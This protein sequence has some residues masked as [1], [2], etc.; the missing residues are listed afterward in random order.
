MRTIF[1]RHCRQ[2]TAFLILSATAAILPAASSTELERTS[3]GD[4]NVTQAISAFG[5]QMEVQKAAVTS[6]VNSALDRLN[7]LEGRVEDI[8]VTVQNLQS[9]MDLAETEINGLK[10]RVSSLESRMANAEAY[11]SWVHAQ[12]DALGVRVSNLEAYVNWLN[13]RLTTLEGDMTSAKNRLAALESELSAL[14]SRVAA[15]ESQVGYRELPI[16]S[17]CP[18]AY[19]VSNG[20]V[21]G[22]EV[23]VSLDATAC[24]GY[25]C[26]YEKF[27][28]STVNR[29]CQDRGYAYSTGVKA[30]YGAGCKSCKNAYWSGSAWEW[31]D[32]DNTA[33]IGSIGCFTGS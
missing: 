7:I 15:L 27:V 8:A 20:S 14:K 10:W 3:V 29:A 22:C 21:W 28:D 13:S 19:A 32:N 31:Y 33:A 16:A 26:S 23:I 6:V 17:R 25:R 12:V 9:R 1:H 2:A 24:G 18:G 5:M 30:T 4:S 11:I